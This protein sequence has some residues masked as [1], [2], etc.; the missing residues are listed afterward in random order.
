MRGMS[1]QRLTW[2]LENWAYFQRDRQSDYGETY[3]GK[4]SSGARSNSSKAFDDLVYEVDAR[5]SEAVTVILSELTPV[6]QA[7]IHNKY[8]DGVYRFPRNNFEEALAQARVFVR[9]G[10]MRRGIE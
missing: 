7:A 4:D 5:C 3:S 2:H 6:Q 10:L 9:A 8:L 1:E